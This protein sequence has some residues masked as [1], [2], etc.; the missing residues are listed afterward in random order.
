MNA[1][2]LAFAAVTLL[3]AP[4]SG[5]QSVAQDP[6]EDPVQEAIREFN[7]H[8][9]GKPNE[10]TV[11]LDPVGDPPAPIPEKAKPEPV[12][13][14]P[15]KAPVL[16]TG[17]APE[18]TQLIN[19]TPAAATPPEEP[20]PKP[21]QGLAVRVEKLQVGTGKID[22]SQVK[23]LA[24][25]PAKPL[26]Q[27]PAGWRIESSENAPPFTREVEL[28][29]GKKITLT[30]R[31]HLLV[32]EADATTVFNVAEPGFDASLGYRQTATVGAIL[33][34]SIRQ[35][36]DD[37]KDLGAT[38]DSLQQLLVSLP[39]PEPQPESKPEIKPAPTRKR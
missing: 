34:H 6:Q 1:T 33:S 16:V 17:K 22:P 3:G 2:R 5:A 15:P 37:S 36:E 23:L 18:G 20:A 26:G 38:I 25:F 29:P 9:S 27:A 14:T 28:S 30:I 4:L 8:D 31:P 19:E 7:R 39:K 35:L 11:V 32:P 13:E 10:V 24:P 12:P 21:H